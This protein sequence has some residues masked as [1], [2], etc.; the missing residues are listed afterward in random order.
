MNANNL[1]TSVLQLMSMG[2]DPSSLMMNMA[3]QNPQLQSL[4]N[5]KNQSNMSWKD[6]TM[7]LA[8]QNNIDITP[9]IQGLSQRGIK[10]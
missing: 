2:K 10:L 6:I 9:L 4:I 3:N 1:I 8:R 7:Q 5:Q